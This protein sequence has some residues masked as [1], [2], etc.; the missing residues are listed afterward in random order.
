MLN[1]K[2]ATTGSQIGLGGANK[3]GLVHELVTDVGNQNHG[4]GQVDREEVVDKLLGG[5]L[6]VTDGGKTNPELGNQHE[7][8]ED[9]T[10]PRANDTGLGTEGQLIQAVTLLLPRAAEEDVGTTHGTPSENRRQTRDGHHPGEGSGLHIGGGEVAKQTQ[11]RCNQNGGE[12]TTLAV[13]VC[14]E[15]GG[16]ALLGKGGKSTRGSV[17]GGVTDGQDSNQDDDIHDR[18]QSFDSCILNG[19]DERRGLGIG[20][21]GTADKFRVVVRH[22]EANDGKGNHVEE[23]NTPEDLLHGSGEGLA[24]I[25][26]FGGG[27]TNK[28]GSSKGKRGVDEHTAETLE[29][30][31]ECTWVVPVLGANVSTFGT[32]TTVED[33]SKDANS[34]VSWGVQI[35]ANSS[36]TYMKPITAMTLMIEK[37]NS[38]SPYPRTPNML[39]ATIKTQKMVTQAAFETPGFQ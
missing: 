30:V 8:V 5:L 6:C 28:F 27:K 19:N 22:Q 39:I 18:R 29:T 2:V 4:G 23:S 20:G 36:A 16:L 17:D 34:Q 7:T 32:T 35:S 11:G 24:G 12:R 1:I 9:E 26:G 21:G 13:D 33:D 25:S 15:P 3:L 38:A 10:D 31:S 14:E 37:T